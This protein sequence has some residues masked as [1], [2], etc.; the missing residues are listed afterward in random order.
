VKPSAW[1]TWLVFE[2]EAAALIGSPITLARGASIEIDFRLDTRN[3]EAGISIS[4]VAFRV[5]DDGYTDCFYDRDVTFETV[6]R[7][8]SKIDQ[9]LI[10][11]IV[12]AGW[13]LMAIVMANALAF[14]GWTLYYWEDRIIKCSQPRFLVMLC[15]GTIIMSSA[16]VT[17]GIDDDNSSLEAADKACMATPWLISMGFITSF[18]A[19]FSKIWRIN[20]I[21]QNPSF[22]RI[23]VTEADV[24]VPFLILFTLNFALLLT[25]TLY[26]PLRYERLRVD[27]SNPLVTYGTCR[28]E[29][30]STVGLA[31]GVLAVNF[32]AIILACAQAYR[33]REISDEFSESKWV[34]VTVASWLQVIIVGLPV[35]FLVKENPTATYMLETTLIFVACTSLLLFIFVPKILFQRQHANDPNSRASK[36]GSGVR[37]FDPDVLPGVK[38]YNPQSGSA[39][40][41][42][43]LGSI[44]PSSEKNANCSSAL[45]IRIVSSPG[46]MSSV[47]QDNEDLL[48]QVQEMQKRIEQLEQENATLKAVSHEVCEQQEKA[49]ENVVSS[50]VPEEQKEQHET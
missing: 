23:T 34:G 22:R 17:I 5:V 7:V 13:V 43:S 37:I 6:L 24:L 50:E 40:R 36:F 38:V 39:S 15:S 14:I 19:L 12:I 41:I 33:A 28:F 21:F 11:S 3:L 4:T 18:S 49:K 47:E 26:D 42:D 27:K 44:T 29:K 32:G 45:G 25:W 8:K 9:N 35:I 16:I 46:I 10:G 48:S 1:P 30:E 31:V 2:E 20:K